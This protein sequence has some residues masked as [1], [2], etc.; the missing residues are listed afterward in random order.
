MAQEAHFPS[1]EEVE[2]SLIKSQDGATVLVTN[3]KYI[4]IKRELFIVKLEGKYLY[5]RLLVCDS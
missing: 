5:N 2:A 4:S 1:K 3:P